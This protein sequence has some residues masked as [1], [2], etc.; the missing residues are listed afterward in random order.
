MPS[1]AEPGGGGKNL[2][3][4]RSLISVSHETKLARQTRLGK[5]RDG[6]GLADD[7][8]QRPGDGQFPFRVA[9]Q[10]VKKTAQAG[11]FA[12]RR[13]GLAAGV[14]SAWPGPPDPLH[15]VHAAS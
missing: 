3:A 13:R 2:R 7:R 9:V 6:F 14:S 1:S 11:R 5:K 12:R 8:A 15:G 10:R 4:S